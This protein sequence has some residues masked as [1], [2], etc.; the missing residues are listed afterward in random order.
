MEYSLKKYKNS[1]TIIYLF[2]NES[3]IQCNC[4]LVTI[5]VNDWLNDLSLWK[6]DKYQG[7]AK[8]TLKE[9]KELIPMVEK[10]MEIGKRYIGG[11]SLAGL[12]SLYAYLE[13]DLFDGCM[14]VSGSL[15]Y[16]GFREYVETKEIRNGKI[17]LSLGDTEELTKHKEMKSVG[18]NT[19]YLYQLFKSKVDQCTYEINKGGHFNEPDKRVLKGINWLLEDEYNECK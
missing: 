15:W 3:S 8:Q 4:N 5:R 13:T 11:Y 16:P 14:S 17:Y 6:T 12:F 9:L 18:D 10:D 19:R 7:N 1:K 2:E